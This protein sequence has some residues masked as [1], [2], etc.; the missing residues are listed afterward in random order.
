MDESSTTCE[1]NERPDESRLDQGEGGAVPSAGDILGDSLVVGATDAARGDLFSRGHLEF[2]PRILLR[3][4]RHR[5]LRGP[6]LQILGAR[7]VSQIP[8]RCAETAAM[9]AV[10]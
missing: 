1:R 9:K 2:L 5:A 3:L 10:N 6:E 7:G 4:L 8:H